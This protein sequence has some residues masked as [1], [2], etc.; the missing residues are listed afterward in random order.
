ML[1]SKNQAKKDYAKELAEYFENEV[2]SQI[3]RMLGRTNYSSDR[4]KLVTIFG[5][6]KRIRIIIRQTKF[7]GNSYIAFGN[8]L[9]SYLMDNFPIKSVTLDWYDTTNKDI[10]F[11]ANPKPTTLDFETYI[12][13]TQNEDL[14]PT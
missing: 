8:E 11:W 6:G 14:F 3:N 10:F 5:E 1:S 9:K 12:G 4:G 13:L 7:R 2:E